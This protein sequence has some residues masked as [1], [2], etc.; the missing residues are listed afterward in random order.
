MTHWAQRQLDVAGTLSEDSQRVLLHRG[1]RA[2]IE[3]AL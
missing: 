1:V 3:E 2:T